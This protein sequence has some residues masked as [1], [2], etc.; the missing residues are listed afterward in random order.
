MSQVIPVNVQ[1]PSAST[2]PVVADFVSHA[3]RV[4][5]AARRDVDRLTPEEWGVPGIYVLLTDDGTHQLYVGQAVDLR[6]RLLHHP[7]RP[8]LAWSRVVA[9]K[10]DTSHGFNSAEIG[11]LEGRV[12]AELAAI[13]GVAVIE[14]KR[15]QDTTLPPHMLL[16]LDEL[17]ASVLA[18]LRLAGVDT[19]K[20]ADELERTS[21]RGTRRKSPIAKRGTV[22]DLLAAGLLRAGAEVHLSQG[23]RAASGTV[24]TSGEIIVAG[25]AYASPSTA[26]QQALGLRSSNGWTTWRVGDLRGP[27]LDA[28]RDRLAEVDGESVL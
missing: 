27:T 19:H 25:V 8:K 23:G 21:P 10:R 9:I 12:A 1:I 6:R 7:S 5:Y 18:A 20:E 26:A 24:T 17:L 13:P 16:S 4:A 11:Y 3:L 2:A 14:G 15:D 22:A 28:L